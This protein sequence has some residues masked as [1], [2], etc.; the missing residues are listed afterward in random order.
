MRRALTT[1]IAAASAR[2]LAASLPASSP[3]EAERRR[4]AAPAEDE[5]RRAANDAREGSR[6]LRLAGTH[7]VKAPEWRTGVVSPRDSKRR[8]WRTAPVVNETGLADAWAHPPLPAWLNETLGDRSPSANVPNII[9]MFWD[10]WPD[11]PAVVRHCVASWVV[12]NPTWRVQ[13]LSD[14]DVLT[15][16]PSG[17][18]R[19]KWSNITVGAHRGDVLRIVLLERFGG[20]WADATLF[21][22][23]PLD[24]WI[25]RAV[26]A[27][28]DWFAFAAGEKP[29]K[30]SPQYGDDCAGCEPPGAPVAKAS[31]CLARGGQ[32]FDPASRRTYN[33]S[34]SFLAAAPGSYVATREAECF[35]GY[36]LKHLK[37]KSYTH[38]HECFKGLAASDKKFAKSW[39]AAVE[40]P[41]RRVVGAVPVSGNHKDQAPPA[42][43][44][45]LRSRVDGVC[46]PHVKMTFKGQYGNVTGTENDTSTVGYL[47]ARTR[48]HLLKALRPCGD[49][50]CLLLGEDVARVVGVG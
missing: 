40:I 11:A 10:R 30:K 45:A 6:S 12:M 22:L 41:S 13:L 34:N 49:W 39:L 20:V 16:L 48:P 50:P 5:R 33:P 27:S 8:T 47:F 29:N 7:P 31:S 21:C 19:E 37:A 25:R 23:L 42:L 44:P 46:G 9:W 15:Y 2:G 26:G 14:A 43:T 36:M 18:T 28:N 17:W 3:N 32:A 1:L 4:D 38:F 35:A 24:R